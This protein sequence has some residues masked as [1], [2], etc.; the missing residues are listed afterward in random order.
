M[1]LLSPT[2]HRRL[3][4]VIGFLLLSTG[5]AILLSLVSYHTQDPSWN[6]ASG[7]RPLNLAGY[8]GAWG[9]DVLVQIFGAAAFLFP[10]LAFLLSWKW[11]R[12]EALDAGAVKI[13]G[14]VLLT[15]SVC[16]ALS[17]APLRLY[18][19]TIPIGGTL[20]LALANYLVDSLNL[21]GALVATATAIVVSLYLV[22]T[23]TLARLGEW[24]AGPIA[25]FQRRAAA[26]R[27]A[28]ALAPVP[29]RRLGSGSGGGLRSP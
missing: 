13:L 21:A 15:L 20:G 19:G 27:L 11:I 25:W 8:P 12:S 6:T 14:S 3:N 29:S 7:S 22:S 5:L 2:E 1:K 16:A 23:F 17:F 24:F 10:L 28:R 9:S 18:G 26:W 4:E